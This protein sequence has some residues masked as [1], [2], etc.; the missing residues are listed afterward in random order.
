MA[1]ILL[2]S[3]QVSIIV[4]STIGTLPTLTAIQADFENTKSNI[5]SV[6]L[7][8]LALFLSGY[9]IQQRT[10]REL[11]IA[12]RP[13]PSRPSPKVNLPDRFKASTTELEDGTILVLDSETEDYSNDQQ[14]AFIEV[15]PTEP[16]AESQEQEEE[17]P[18]QE[19]EPKK[20]KSQIVQELQ[21]KI[22]E[23]V[24]GV[25]HPDPAAKNQKPISRA[26]RRRLIKEEIKRLSHTDQPM[27]YQRRLW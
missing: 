22:A 16:D 19:E 23:Q 3:S 4:T 14:Q 18:H 9:A 21:A 8:T 7:C 24:S 26:E 10:L 27:G 13:R 5:P 25:E 2:T 11:R 1:K 17:P 12:I 6:V 20:D 15:K